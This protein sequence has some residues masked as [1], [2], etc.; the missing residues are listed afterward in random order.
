MHTDELLTTPQEIKNRR[1]KRGLEWDWSQPAGFSRAIESSL[2]AQPLP[3][4]PPIESDP[5]AAY[6]IK[7]RPDL[8]K[9]Q[10]P[11]NVKLFD[12]M[13]KDHPNRLFVESVIQGLTDGFWPMCDLPDSDSPTIPNHA[14]C[15]EHPQ[16]LADACAEEVA[17]GRYSQPFHTLLAGMKVSPLL[18]AAK[19]NSTKMRVCTDMSYGQHSLN[20]LVRK[21]ECRVAF[22]SIISFAPYIVEKSKS[23]QKLL[24]WKS[25]VQNAYRIIPMCL[26]WQLRQIVCINNLFYVDRCANFGSSASPKIWCSVF[27]LVLWL[28]E[29]KLG[30]EG[31]NN[32]MDDTWG[33][34]LA[35]TIVEYK[36]HKIPKDQALFLLLFD[37]L[38][39]PW[40]WKKQV[41]GSDLEVI[42]F[43]LRPNEL[44]FTLTPEKKQALVDRIE[45]FVLQPASPLRDWQQLLGWCSWA[46][47]IFPLGRFALQSAWDKIGGKSKRFMSVPTNKEIQTDLR[48]LAEALRRSDGIYFLDASIWSTKDADIILTADACP[49][50][51][52]VWVP[53]SIEG[54]HGSLPPPSREIYWAELLAVGHA[55]EIGIKRQAKKMLICTDSRNVC[56]LFLSHKPKPVV[57]DLFSAIIKLMVAENVDIRVAHLPG[58]KNVFADALSR[59]NLSK[60]KSLCINASISPFNST[61]N[62]PDGGKKNSRNV[63]TVSTRTAAGDMWDGR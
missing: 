62:F 50:G 45:L 55:V 12:F 2:H 22:D 63:P 20:D 31:M 38:S 43:H 11:I 19:S 49:T 17:R 41:H 59:G 4:P 24:I 6:A 33:V 14:N 25:D 3:R 44:I 56:D 5:N 29:K 27:S 52:G 7:R 57:K 28:A 54:F 30:I 46:L 53:D 60:V 21:D 40:E 1:F 35:N 18:L 37:T 36:S 15:N 47:N 58:S 39:I 61:S 26:Q 51:Y 32:L 10:T 23:G 48:W 8:F 42:G 34:A 13:L 9:I 16:M